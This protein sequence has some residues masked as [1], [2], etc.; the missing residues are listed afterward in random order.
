MQVIAFLLLLMPSARF[1]WRCRQMPE[2]GY[3]HDDAILFISAKSVA[4]GDYRIESLPEEPAQTKYP[5]LFPAYLSLIWRMD[6]H[7]PENLELGT[8]FSFALL[9]PLLFMAWLYYRREFTERRAWVLTALL[10][11]NPYII[12]FGR[13]MFSEIF[14]MG[15]LIAALLALQRPGVRWAI[16]AGILAGCAYLSRTAGIALLISVPAVMLWKKEARRAAAF[17][18]AMLPFVLGWMIWTRAHALHST[19]TTLAYYTDYLRFQ[20]LNVGPD[21]FLNVL[22]INCDQEL[23]AMGT[24]IFGDFLPL[25]A[26]NILTRVTAVAMIAGVVRLFRQGVAEHYTIFGLISAGMLAVWHYPPTERFVLPM[27]PLLLAGLVAELTHLAEMIN[28]A[29]RHKHTSQRVVA[30]AFG[31]LVAALAVIA[32]GLQF[33]G[34]FTSLGNVANSK[35]KKLKQQR[36]AYAWIE[37]NLP[38]SATLLSYDDT[39]MYLYTGRRGN[40][41]PMMPKWWYA[42]NA[43]ALVDTYKDLNTYCRRRGLQYVYFTENDTD[44]ELGEVL[45]G[46]VQEEVKAEPGLI[47]IYR[48][49]TATIYRVDDAIPEQMQTSSSR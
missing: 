41:I 9:P 27:F 49:P 44:R 18:S 11:V 1:A 17:A 43:D 13:T 31:V 30:G 39:L 35:I 32:V 6:P 34:S 12:L 14:F 21:N 23:W 40:C 8:W 5:P 45:R 19:D 10:A 4:H 46:R 33:R 47:P 2:F 48:M 26:M 7:F 3:L 37:K 42:E 38:P 29:L 36:A 16:V 24:L 25:F 22:W 15:W 20:F 28:G